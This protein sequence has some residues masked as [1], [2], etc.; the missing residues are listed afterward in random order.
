MGLGG[1]KNKLLKVVS[2]FAGKVF[3]ELLCSTVL[4][5]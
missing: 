4:L 2:I 1:I 5:L 3:G